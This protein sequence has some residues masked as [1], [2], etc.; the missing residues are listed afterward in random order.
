M[1]GSYYDDN[2]GHWENTDDPDVRAF[3]RRVQAE[4]VEKKCRGC[5]RL[6]KLRPQYGYCDGCATKREN[7]WEC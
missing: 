2:F 6:V 5:G 1:G 4:S 7:G 3:Y